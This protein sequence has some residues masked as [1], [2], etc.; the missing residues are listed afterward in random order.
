MSDTPPSISSHARLEEIFQSYERDIRVKNYRSCVWLTIVFMLAGTS[1]DWI[2]YGKA[3]AVRFLPLRLISVAVLAAGGGLL[4]TRLGARIHRALGI[5]MALP[6]IA[7][8][9]WMIAITDGAESPYYAGL[10]LVLLGAV[11]MMRWPLADSITVVVITLGAY[12]LACRLHGPTRNWPIFFNNLYFLLVTGVLTTAGT[13]VYNRI[14]FSE[15]RS[16]YDLDINRKQLEA[17]NLKLEQNN[18]K[19]MELDEAKSRFFANISHELRTPLTLLIAPLEVLMGEA[20]S[21]A[22]GQVETLTTMHA[23]AMRLLKLINDL[24]DLVGLESGQ[25]QVVSAPVDVAAF[26]ESQVAA[27]KMMAEGRQITVGCT[28]ELGMPRALLDEEKLERICLNLLFNAIKFTPPGGR[29]DLTADMDDGWL[30]IC[31]TDTGCGIA[32]DH[33]LHVFSRF[34][35]AD[36]SPQRKQGGLGIGLAL[37]KDLVEAHGGTI[38][39]ASELGKGTAMT[40]RLPFQAAVEDGARAALSVEPAASAASGG[41]QQWLADLR[42]RADLFPGRFSTE[43]APPPEFELDVAE[44][45]RVSPPRLLLAEDEADMRRFLK[46]QLGGAFEIIEAANGAEAVQKAIEHRPDVILCDVMMP[47]KD[48]FQVCTELRAN[49]E[50]RNVPLVML[51]AKADEQT[52]LGLLKAG[53]TDFL[54]KPFSI[55]EVHVRL[56][57]LARTR[58]HSKL[59]ARQKEQLEQS[60]IQLKET[61][62]L[63]VRNEKLA[64][65]GRLSAGLIHEINNPLHYAKQ[66]LYV[67]RR[68]L[69]KLAD[70][71]DNATVEIIDDVEGGIDRVAGI[72][73]DLRGFASRQSDEARHFRL[74]D[75]VEMALRFFS[76][77]WKDG[78]EREIDVPEELE[79][80]GDRNHFLQVLVN[81]IQN[82][83]D[84]V[85][86]KA[87]APPEKPLI[88]IRAAGEGDAVVVRIRDNGPGIAPEIMNQ[89]FDPFFTTKDVGEGMGLGLAI[90]HRIIAEHRGRITARSE[91]GRLTEFVIELPSSEAGSLPATSPAP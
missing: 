87:Y 23:N 35:Q 60:M 27:V 30:Q 70:T 59:L 88:S 79:V 73:S 16:R 22:P 45:G 50:L 9:A 25:V 7:S 14:R 89:I 85:G 63:L 5:A 28:V 43:P 67:L 37:V 68:S 42:R 20:T 83:L 19:L 77:T 38:T 91:P 3:G 18:R 62:A 46:S 49:P 57:N 26:I 61:E 78:V 6:L 44:E 86:A 12:L 74:K 4:M 90:T 8:I 40:V 71:D 80:W 52:K 72:I 11:V 13:W 84:A 34:W 32:P 64:A 53:A 66:A 24:L 65:L 51:T 36:T 54:A 39:A 56:R 1:L 55:T 69:K 47:E 81:L 82:A 17:A 29:V 58:L 76:A 75:A 2:V 33:L 10:N 15:F 48:G 21:A 41:H 31:V